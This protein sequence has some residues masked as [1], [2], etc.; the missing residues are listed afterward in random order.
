MTPVSG[1]EPKPSASPSGKTADARGLAGQ[2]VGDTG[3]CAVTQTQLI[4]RGYEIADLAANATFEEVAFLLLVRPKPSPAEL[5][6]FKDEL[7]SMRPIPDGLVDL[8]R[9]IAVTNAHPMSILRTGVSY[10]SHYD[11]ETEDNSPEAELRKAKR[12]LAQI[13]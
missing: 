11:P 10:L 1:T 8:L 12:L 6:D 13:P 4:Y 5:R 9:K 2:P 3:I 7:V